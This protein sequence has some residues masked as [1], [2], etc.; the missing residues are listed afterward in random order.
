MFIVY[1]FRNAGFWGV[2]IKMSDNLP[3][4]KTKNNFLL[5]RIKT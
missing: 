1:L 3:H 5:Y 4:F 2:V